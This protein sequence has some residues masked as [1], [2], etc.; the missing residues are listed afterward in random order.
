MMSRRFIVTSLFGLLLASG[1]LHAQEALRPEVGKPLQA[2]QELIK[3]KKYKEALAKIRDADAV[4]SKNAHETLTIE[5][6]RFVAANGSNDADAAARSLDSLLVAGKLSA[7][8][9]QQYM[10]AV[11]VA[12]YRARE[13]GKA[14]SWTQRYFKEGG[15]DGQMRT[16]LVQSYYLNGDYAN[17]AKE[18]NVA[19][20]AAEKAGGKPDQDRLEMLAGCYLK[21]NDMN[22]YTSALEKLATWYPKKEYWADLLARIQ[23]KPGFADRL[24]LDVYRL[25]LASGIVGGA[26]DYMEMAQLALQQGYPMEAKKIVD[27]GY[28]KS[29][30]GTGS[31]VERHK[32]LRNLVDKQLAEDQKGLAQGEKQ[33]AAAKE[34]TGL[35][36]IGLN[37]IFNGQNDKGLALMEQGM[38]KGGVK[39]PDDARLHL[40]YAYLLAGQKAKAA[41]TFKAVQG[42][43]GSADLARLWLLQ[44]QH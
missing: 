16:V 22:G 10:Q 40:G 8:E 12:Y 38:G 15:S 25:K 34:G 4:G 30:L 41:Q 36:N 26:G 29:L 27:E 31:D 35:V 1:G 37:L 43:D 18:L 21:L 3:A 17:A 44:M 13:Y 39:R 24:S 9:Q 14:I 6:M 5:R 2:A 42:T 20:Q 23:K 33:A 32:R 11:A 7:S 19:V 28:A